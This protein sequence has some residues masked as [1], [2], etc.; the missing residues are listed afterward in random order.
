MKGEQIQRVSALLFDM[1][2]LLLDTERQ[3]RNAFARACDE[4]GVRF[5]ATVYGRCLGTTLDESRHILRDGY[6]SAFPLL[7][8]EA[9]CDELYLQHQAR[10]GID[11]RPGAFELLQVA[12]QFKLHTALVTSTARPIAGGRLNQTQLAAFFRVRVCGGE[13]ALPKP[14]ADPYLLAAKCLGIAPS[15]CLVLEDSP[16]GV[17]AGVAAGMQVVQVPDL[18]APTPELLALGHSVH[19]SLHETL[20]MLAS[21]RGLSEL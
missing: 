20:K 11:T 4:H 5:D 15:E 16:N 12:T 21:S 2:G 14:A 13:A 17:R 10:E 7:D 1:D 6:G 18:I 9:R 3:N 19:T 8:I